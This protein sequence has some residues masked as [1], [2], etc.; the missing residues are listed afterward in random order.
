MRRIPFVLAALLMVS[1]QAQTETLEPPEVP[2]ALKPPSG[3]VPIGR[4]LAAGVQVYTCKNSVWTL[5]APNATLFDS[6]AQMLAK[7]FEGPTWMFKDGS[8]IVGTKVAEAPAPNPRSVPWLL[9]KTKT[10]DGSGDY[11]KVT[12]I[13]RVDTGGGVAPPAATCTDATQD[14]EAREAYVAMYYF[15]AKQ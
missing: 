9:L 13:Q 7:H 15:Y 14:A 12:Y 11:S 1:L 8:R 3:N 4:G 2:E 5:K 6:A 10:A